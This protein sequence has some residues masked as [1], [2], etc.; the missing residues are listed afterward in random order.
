MIRVSLGEGFIFDILSVLDVKLTKFPAN[1]RAKHN[2]DF[3]VSEIEREIGVKKLNEVYA[4]PEYKKLFAINSALFDLIDE[5]HRRKDRGDPIEDPDPMNFERAQLKHALQ[6][7][8][9]PDSDFVE[10]K[11]GYK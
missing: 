11:L 2:Y 7:K 9:F 6:T 10:Q 5:N 8:F 1:K 4:S 3:F